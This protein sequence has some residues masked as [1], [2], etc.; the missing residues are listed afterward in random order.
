MDLSLIWK[1]FKSCSNFFFKEGLSVFI[2][3]LPSNLYDSDEES[4]SLIAKES[5]CI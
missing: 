3:M 2:N 1:A 5:S 4:N